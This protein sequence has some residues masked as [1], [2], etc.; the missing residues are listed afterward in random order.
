LGAKQDIH[1]LKIRSKLGKVVEVW[2]DDDGNLK[3]YQEKMDNGVLELVFI[4]SSSLLPDPATFLIR[5]QNLV[6]IKP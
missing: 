1:H 5:N 2:I 3:R 4:S 6:L